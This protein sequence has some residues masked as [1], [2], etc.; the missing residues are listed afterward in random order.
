MVQV[1]VV[2]LHSWKISGVIPD[3]KVGCLRISVV[4]LHAA[5][6]MLE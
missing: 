6:Q 2:L 4:L 5:K 1:L 3:D